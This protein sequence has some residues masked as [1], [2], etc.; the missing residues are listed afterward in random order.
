MCDVLMEYMTEQ[1]VSPLVGLFTNNIY[2]EAQAKWPRGRTFIN[3]I[4]ISLQSY[5]DIM[6]LG[7]M[8]LDILL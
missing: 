8:L 7:H 1:G 3:S 5:L 2:E 6:E 4:F